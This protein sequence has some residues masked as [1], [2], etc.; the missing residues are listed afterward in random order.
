MAGLVVAVVAEKQKQ[1]GKNKIDT[2][3]NIGLMSAK[4]GLL[5]LL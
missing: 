1:W 5:A 3:V 4:G 2:L